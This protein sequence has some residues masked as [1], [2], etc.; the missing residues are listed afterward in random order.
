MAGADEKSIKNIRQQFKDHG[1]F[2]TPPELAELLK[3]YIDFTPGSVYDPTCGQGNLLSVFPDET[4]KYGQEI[5]SDELEKA[6]SRLKNF[7]GY[8]GDTLRDDGF[9]GLK[10]DAIVANPPFSIR[11]EPNENDERFEGCPALPPPSKADYAFIIHILH[12]LSD[13]GKAICLEFPGILYRG[14]REG[15]IR[16]W[17]VDQNYIERVVHIPGNTFVDTQIAT[18]IVVLNKAK[19][20]TDIIFEDKENSIEKCVRY[21]DVKDNDYSLSVSNYIVPE[22]S[23]E[24]IDPA[25][26]ENRARQQFIKRLKNE[27]DFEMQICEMEKISIIPFLDEIQKA[28]DEYYSISGG[29]I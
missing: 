20:S 10:F 22:K 15:K 28:I 7:I 1:V 25:D 3:T 9:K 4:T 24:D 11:W 14:Q 18:C 6:K 21:E 2:Y 26:L 19:R 13:T 17:L 12:H 23:K 27:L 29:L 5:F 8:S 16:Q